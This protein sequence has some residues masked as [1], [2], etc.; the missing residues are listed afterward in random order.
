M[1]YFN[2]FTLNTGNN[3]K[4]YPNEIDRGFL[5]KFLPIIK[6]IVNNGMCDFYDDTKL[7]ITSEEKD[8]YMATIYTEHRGDFTP[9]LFTAATSN[10]KK[11]K[12]LIK[13][14]ESLRNIIGDSRVFLPPEAPLIVDVV[15]PAIAIRMDLIKM[16]GDLSRCLAWG[17]LDPGAVVK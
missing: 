17:I 13:D 16:T 8:Y 15:L 3:R 7:Q 5:F 2:H 6:N 9:I 14:V 1:E 4:T 12:R 11:R 10:P